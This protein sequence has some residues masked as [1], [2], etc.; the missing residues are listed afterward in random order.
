V[1]IRKV[2]LKAEARRQYWQTIPL[3]ALAWLGLTTFLSFSSIGLGIHLGDGLQWPFGWVLAEAVFFGIV[4]A[5]SLAA[6]LRHSRARFTVLPLVVLV[7]GVLPR[8][9]PAGF[10]LNKTLMG[11]G[12][13][14]LRRRLAI[15]GMLSS[16]AAAAGWA[17]FAVFAGTQGAKHV[18]LRTELELAEKLQQTLA[19]PLAVGNAEYEIHGRSAPSSQMGGDLLDAV[20]DPSAGMAVYVADVAGHGI[21]AG[22]FMGMVKS[23]VRMALLKIGPLA[24]LLGDLN[25]IVFEVKTAPA[26]YVTFACLRCGET[27][28]VEYSIAGSRPILHYSAQFKTTTPLVMEQFPLGLFGNATSQSRVVEIQPGTSWRC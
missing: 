24:G 11:P 22:V 20:D 13:E 3:S 27:G 9:T 28:K 18:R 7:I 5:L 12:F 10:P 25:R 14:H 6:I 8:I 2:W 4:M 19:P 1:N 23:S 16:M 17:T 15:E 26:T 21:Q